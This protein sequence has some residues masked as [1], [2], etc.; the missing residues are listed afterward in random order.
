MTRNKQIIRQNLWVSSALSLLIV[1]VVIPLVIPHLPVEPETPNGSYIKSGSRVF[2]NFLEQVK[3]EHGVLILGTSET[4]N[5]LSGNNYWAL[6]QRDKDL[7]RNFYSLGGAGRC[8]HV[9]FPLILD[10]PGAFRDLEVI[11]YINPTYWRKG[12]NNFHKAYFE[13]YVDTTLVYALEY[14]AIEARIY[15]EFMK[16]A[17]TERDR[18]RAIAIDRMIERYRSLFYYD[19]NRFI[20]GKDPGVHER[21]NIEDF[22]TP[23]RMEAAK[24]QVN[25]AY[26]ATDEFLRQNTSFPVIDT[27]S[28]FQYDLLQAFIQMVREHGIHCTFYLGPFN[29][30]YCREK[31]PELLDDYY[32]TMENIREILENSGLPYIDGSGQSTVPGTFSDIQHISEYGAYLTA[33]QIKEYY[34]KND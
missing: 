10:N 8:A 7:D 18:P 24:K 2:Y 29:E 22:Y 5:S 19:L 33:L 15:E 16:P 20:E 26:N 17:I 1:T 6:L 4:G 14:K 11:Y 32:D 31:N 34:E 23:G 30:I 28:G 25:P 9:Y 12:L 27:A 3:K 21:M 13:R